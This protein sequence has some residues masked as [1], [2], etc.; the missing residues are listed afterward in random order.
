MFIANDLIS[1]VVKSLCCCCIAA[2]PE[3]ASVMICL[4]EL[5]DFMRTNKALILFRVLNVLSSSVFAL[6]SQ[7]ITPRAEITLLPTYS[8]VFVL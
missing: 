4:V 6:P 1:R 8:R 5:N 2:G 3:A 7:S